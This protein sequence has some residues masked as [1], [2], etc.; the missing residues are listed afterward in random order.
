MSRVR[1]GLPMQGG[2]PKEISPNS[3]LLWTISGGH[4]LRL[5]LGLEMGFRK[6]RFQSYGLSHNMVLHV[7]VI[8]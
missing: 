2:L 8:I 3:F 6:K 1:K 5:W 4:G 7:T